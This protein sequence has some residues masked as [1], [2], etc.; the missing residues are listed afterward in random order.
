MANHEVILEFSK[1]AAEHTAS[2]WKIASGF[3][4]LEVLIIS[5]VLVRPR[6]AVRRA[7]VFWLSLSVVANILS[8]I[9][10]YISDA[11]LLYALKDY[12][13]DGSVWHP[14]REAE[15]FNLLQMIALTAGLLSFV[16]AFMRYSRVLADNLIRASAHLPA[17]KEHEHSKKGH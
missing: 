7:V 1:M 10:G 6:V 15:V 9:C 4:A 14:S 12:T 2:L 5:Q 11:G 16:F 8:L 3:I 17:G 13:V